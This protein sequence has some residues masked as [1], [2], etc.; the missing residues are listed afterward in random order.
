MTPFKALRGLGTRSGAWVA[1]SLR[2][3]RRPSLLAMLGL[4]AFFGSAQAAS[5]W[6]LTS[7]SPTSGCPGTEVAF[8]GTSFSGSSSTVQWSDPAGLFYTEVG[9]AAKVIS[10][11]KATAVVPTFL[12]TE[13]HSGTVSIDRSNTVSF[14]YTALA[15]CLKGATGATG[16]TGAAGVTGATGAQ[17]VTGATGPAGATGGQ[18][19]TGPEG[20]TGAAGSTGSQGVAGATGLTGPTGETGSTGRQGSTGPQGP[21]VKT[22]AGIVQSDGSVTAGSAFTVSHPSTGEYVITFPPGT[23]SSLPVMTVTPF[24]I[25]GAVV[26]PVDFSEVGLGSGEA[27]FTI[28]LSSSVPADTP[29]DNAFQFIAAAS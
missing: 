28:R 25:N 26:A 24:G 8:T 27:I 13:S 19:P 15:N 17:G 3:V 7:V 23:W 10:S 6:H 18:G 1:M 14:T 16:P 2:A 9:T 20:P 21:G 4:L 22:I 11:T 29:Q 5:A 12:S